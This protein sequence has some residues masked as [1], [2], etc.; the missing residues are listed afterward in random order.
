MSLQ[1]HLD[2]RRNTQ[3]YKVLS[4]NLVMFMKMLFKDENID[5]ETILTI[6]GILDTNSFDI[7]LPT[8]KVI[9]RA[10]YYGAS[11]FAHSC[12]PNARH[13]FKENMQMVMFATSMFCSYRIG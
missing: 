13:L 4:M 2:D 8:T 11:M 6:C 9:G 1:S 5:K 7:K 10:I 12:R 3:L